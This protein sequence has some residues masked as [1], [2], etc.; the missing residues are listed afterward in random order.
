MYPETAKALDRFAAAGGK[1]VFVGKEPYKSPGYHNHEVKDK[2]VSTAVAVLKKYPGVALY[3]AP[4]KSKTMIDWYKGVQAKFNIKPYFTTDK[5]Q[6]SVNQVY[7]AFGDVDVFFISNCNAHERYE[8]NAEFH[9]NSSKKAWIW[10][11]E[12]GKRFLYPTEG[13]GNKLKIKLGPAE[14]KLIVFDKAANG[15]KQVPVVLSATPFLRID[16]PWN[17]VLNHLDGSKKSLKLNKL[18]DFK[19]HTELVHFAGN[20][21]YENTFDL[22][23]ISKIKYLNLGKVVGVTE[24][25]LNGVHLGNRWYG[26]HIYPLGKSLKKGKN[27]LSIKL[28]TT[29]GNYMHALKDNKDAAKWVIDRKQKLFPMGM[30]GPVELV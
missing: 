15:E 6:A 28:T 4:D 23:D 7:Y 22:K 13:A 27:V 30:L 21:V 5:P 9:I 26:D 18:V 12:T 17:L 2:E 19:G 29:L 1:I 14:A 10:D 11:P 3:P 8:F 20:A 24:V 16:T 25:T